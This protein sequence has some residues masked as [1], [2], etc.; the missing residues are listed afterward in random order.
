MQ[1]IICVLDKSGSMGV[2]ADD[3]VGGFNAFLDEQKKIGDANLTVVWFDTGFEVGYSGSIMD[4]VPLKSWPRG[5]MTALT[6]AMGKTFNHV[7]DRFSKEQPETV[8][9]AILTDGHENASV[10]FTKEAVAAL[11]KEHQDKYGWEVVFLAADQDAW[12]AAQHYGISKGDTAN[13]SS[14]NTMAGFSVMS[15]AVAS[16]RA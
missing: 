7:K 3:A 6:D 4:A 16:R 1:E 14:S 5:T 10:E 8:V 13:Y 9:M 15:S 11:I 12:G 2:V